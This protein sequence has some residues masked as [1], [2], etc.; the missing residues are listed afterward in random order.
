MINQY[1]D[2]MYNDGIVK[3]KLKHNY[4][5]IKPIVAVGDFEMP[6][7]LKHIIDFVNNT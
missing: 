5:L 7:Y 4:D 6:L 1:P 3:A 2:D